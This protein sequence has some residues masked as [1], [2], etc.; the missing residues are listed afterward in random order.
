MGFGC[1]TVTALSP[2]G[3][4]S[5]VRVPGVQ[6]GATLAFSFYLTHKQITHLS[7]DGLIQA[8]ID[9]GSI[10]YPTGIFAACLVGSI[11]LYLVIERPFM[12]LRDRILK[13]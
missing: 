6:A 7:R 2:I 9:Q 10:L 8:G 13:T 5:K 1:L 12:R 3:V 4:L 11:L